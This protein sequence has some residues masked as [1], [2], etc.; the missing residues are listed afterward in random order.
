M[1]VHIQQ[2]ANGRLKA[3]NP[4]AIHLRIF[5]HTFA[6]TP[7]PHPHLVLHD[8]NGQSTRT[9]LHLPIYRLHTCSFPMSSPQMIDHARD[10]RD[11]GLLSRLSVSCA[12]LFNWASASPSSPVDCGLL[13]VGA[14]RSKKAVAD[15]CIPNLGFCTQGPCNLSLCVSS[16]QYIH[17]SRA[18]PNA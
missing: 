17:I 18:Q 3:C 5:P 9:R 16:F 12:Y 8:R 1:Y 4:R 14:R 11:N 10:K 6:T 13:S 7:F 2:R 15:P